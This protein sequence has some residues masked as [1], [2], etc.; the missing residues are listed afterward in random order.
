[1]N[2]NIEKLINPAYDVP[3]ALIVYFF[4]IYRDD[5]KN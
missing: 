5:D 1:M 3:R 4:K 2:I